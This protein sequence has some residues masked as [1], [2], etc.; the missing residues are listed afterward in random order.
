M[1]YRI[2]EIRKEKKMTQEELGEK[3]NVSRAVISDLETGKK[4][5]TSTKTLSKIAAALGCSVTDIFLQ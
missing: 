2:R 5:V 1:E 4:T 3:A